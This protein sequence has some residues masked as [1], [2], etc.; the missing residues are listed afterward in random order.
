[1]KA[2]CTKVYI[3]PHLQAE[4]DMHAGI[5]SLSEKDYSLAYSYF[6]EAFDTFNLPTVKK[7]TKALRTLKLMVLSKIMNGN[8]DEI[9]S[10][11][12]GKTGKLYL[13]T[14]FY[15]RFEV[16]WKRY[17][18]PQ[19]YRTSRQEEIRSGIKA[20]CDRKSG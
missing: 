10:I 12:Y 1:M 16:R 17:N 3:E 13:L 4:I 2:L 18:C 14:V 9:N 11:I 20:S 15:K 8:L 5:I 7:P 6:Y 19:K